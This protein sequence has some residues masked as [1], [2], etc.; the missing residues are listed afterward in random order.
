MT[1][2]NPSPCLALTIAESGNKSWG[3][4]VI[5]CNLDSSTIVVTCYTIAVISG[6]GK[7]KVGR[8]RD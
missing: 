4:R 6:G 2:F 7:Y 1:L 5:A 3:S 8:D